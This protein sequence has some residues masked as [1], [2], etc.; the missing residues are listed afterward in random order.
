[1]SPAPAKQA[2]LR[3]GAI[4]LAAFALALSNFVVVLDITIANVSVSHIAGSLAVSPSQGTW[5]ITSYAVAEAICVPLT[6]WLASRFGAVRVFM[7]SLLGFGLFSFLCGVSGNLESLVLFRVMQGLC[8]GPIMPMSQTLMLRLFPPAKAG[9]AMGIWAMTTVTAPIAGPILGGLISDN[10]SWHWIFFINLP[11]VALCGTL[12]WIL[13]RRYETPTER[14][15]I[16][17]VGLALLVVWV[18]ALQILL[19]KGREEDWFS[20]SLIVTL[21]IVA[22]LGFI[23]FLIWELT[24]RNPIV[25]LSV[26]RFRG[27]TIGVIAQSTTYAAFFAQ[28]VLV[29]LFLQS[30]LG[31]TATWAG[32][33]VAPMGIMAVIVSPIAAGLVAKTDVRRLVTFGVVWLGVMTLLRTGWV[34]SMDYW[35]IA[36]PQFM[37]GIGMPFFFIGTTTL[38]LGAVN[39]NQTASAAGLQNFLRTLAGAMATSLTTTFWERESKIARTELVGVIHPPANALGTGSIADQARATLER[40][41]DVES[42]TLAT[43]TVF[44]ICAAIFIFAAAVV[45]LAPAP[46]KGA[47][48]P[49]GGH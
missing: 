9:Q 20:S 43:N 33:A 19:D 15:P 48:A 36:L 22:V 49:M 27:F 4:A 39:P 13:V 8:G 41:V 6:G 10:L 21:A 12:A 7:L 30:N 34:T 26:F 32:Y 28:V 40:L 16:D 37:Q 11:V 31:Y 45:W 38:A 3:G 25:D 29:P 44:L 46:K 47:S 42:T 24:E 2:P 35:T 23:A 17:F 5:V 1:M 18:G 14:R